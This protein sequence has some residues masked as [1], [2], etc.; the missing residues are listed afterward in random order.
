M[1]R[2]RGG[3]VDVILQLLLALGTGDSIIAITESAVA[4]SSIG[5]WAARAAP[6]ATQTLV[7]WPHAEESDLIIGVVVCDESAFLLTTPRVHKVFVVDLPSGRV[8][9]SI[10]AAELRDPVS[11]T[12]DCQAGSLYVVQVTHGVA[13][14]K[15]ADGS[16]QRSYSTP[17]SF[18]P[19]PQ[20]SVV[21]SKARRLLYIGGLWPTQPLGYLKVPRSKMFDDVAL[22]CRLSLDSGSGTPMFQPLVRGCRGDTSTC[23]RMVFTETFA[24]ASGIPA[25]WFYAQ[26][27]SP[28]VGV[29]DDT[30]KLSKTIEIQSAAFKTDGSEVHVGDSPEAGL[31]WSERNST[32]VR[33]FAIQ[34]GIEVV[35]A[36]TKPGARP[37]SAITF[38]TFMDTISLSGKNLSVPTPL[39]DLPLG[40]AP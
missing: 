21:L 20:S 15:I 9:R 22:G 10:G 31:A 37:G 26:G 2:G 36:T 24:P 14:F 23:R 12:A 5:R 3:L 38:D 40:A 1:Y 17:T 6:L 19:S 30:G 8:T 16:L 34:D 35:Y 39:P 28:A 33:L 25:K 32:I 13:K 27:A 11:L 4:E 29:I 18:V 7:T